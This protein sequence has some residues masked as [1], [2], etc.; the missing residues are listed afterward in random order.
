[1]R[2][3]EEDWVVWLGGY[4]RDGMKGLVYDYIFGK[5]FYLLF[6]FIFLGGNLF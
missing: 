6:L 2:G 5:V 4:C 3:R 1:M